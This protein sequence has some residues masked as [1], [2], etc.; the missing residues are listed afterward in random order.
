[1][2]RK[3][4]NQLSLDLWFEKL[5]RISNPPK[6]PEEIP[7]LYI[8]S[9]EKLKFCEICG[10]VTYWRLYPIKVKGE[11]KYLWRCSECRR[12]RFEKRIVELIPPIKPKRIRGI[13]EDCG[14]F[15]EDLEW[16]EG[17]YLCP[18]CKEGVSTKNRCIL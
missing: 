8:S 6:K 10:E 7:D 16:C 4:F 1:M 12:S 13:C 14:E 3:N 5:K 2:R 17:R 9:T 15:C 11:V 18:N